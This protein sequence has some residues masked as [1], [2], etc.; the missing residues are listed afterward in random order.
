VVITPNIGSG[1]SATP[2]RMRADPALVEALARA[3]RWKRLLES[4][5]FGS[6]AELAAAERI[7]RSFLGKTLRLTLLAP[8]IVEAIL[9]GRQPTD[10]GLSSLLE[11]MP[12]IW[13]EQRSTI[14]GLAV[15]PSR[16]GVHGPSRG[17][18]TP[19]PATGVTRRSRTIGARLPHRARHRCLM[20]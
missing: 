20:L 7:D 16:P 6:L 4:G 2:A 11:S 14:A 9:D 1:L 19:V 3:Y 8:A 17:G 15:A 12:A 10:I 5:R 18:Q 13:E